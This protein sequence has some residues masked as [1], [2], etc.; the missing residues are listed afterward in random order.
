M[1]RVMMM[2][3]VA[4]LAIGA[5]AGA[6]SWQIGNV[7]VPANGTSGGGLNTGADLAN[8]VCYLYIG[9][10]PVAS[11]LASSID[12]GT[13]SIASAQ[14]FASTSATGAVG[15][16]TT[17]SYVSQ[18][19]SAY[20]VVFTSAYTGASWTG[21]YMVSSTITK[22]FGTSGNQTYA[23]LFNTTTSTWTAVP[24]PSSMALLAIG[25]AAVGLRRKLR[26]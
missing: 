12:N 14:D 22:S 2:L 1:K 9:T 8:A 21:S 18:N 20:V 6:V 19:V 15:A 23:F 5:Q 16:R 24:E 25:A 11:T 13:F 17:G 7:N 4:A 10:A 26:K 3:A